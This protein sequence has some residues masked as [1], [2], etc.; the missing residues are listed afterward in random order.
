[1][2]TLEGNFGNL[3]L[4]GGGNGEAPPQTDKT[5]TQLSGGNQGGLVLSN[6]SD[7]GDEELKKKIAL[8][9]HTLFQGSLAQWFVLL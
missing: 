7:S 5:P 9:Y 3:S 1:V 2:N 8:Y 4:G 6:V